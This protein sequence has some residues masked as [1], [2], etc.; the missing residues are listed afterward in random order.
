MFVVILTVRTLV[1]LVWMLHCVLCL[2]HSNINIFCNFIRYEFLYF[3]I[4][5][6]SIQSTTVRHI[7]VHFAEFFLP[8]DEMILKSRKLG[9]NKILSSKVFNKKKI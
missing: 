6:I 2:V 1:G 5:R 7:L 9:A 4:F 8:E 3:Y